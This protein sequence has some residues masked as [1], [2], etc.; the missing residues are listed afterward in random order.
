MP[1]RKPLLP[2]LLAAGL[3][4]G[5]GLTE[6]Q[7]DDVFVPEL[8]ALEGAVCGRPALLGPGPI[9][10]L[11]A[12]AKQTEVSPAGAAAASASKAAPAGDAP[13]LPGLGSRSYKVSTASKLAQR[14]F[15]QGLRLA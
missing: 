3:L 9:A 10:L 1:K 4:T 8:A 15:D 11:L 12:Q 6:A 2:A 13:L 7:S 14:Y 5:E